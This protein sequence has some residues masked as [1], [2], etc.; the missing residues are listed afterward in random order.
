MQA[1]VIKALAINAI[2][3]KE[4][5]FRCLNLASHGIYNAPVLVVIKPCHARWKKQNCPSA[6]TKYQ[7]LHVAL[8]T[9][10]KPF[11]IFSVHLT[12]TAYTEKYQSSILP[13]D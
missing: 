11:V 3:T 4:L 5:N 2:Y 13:L 12:Y 8:Q 6:L 1:F 7:K 9:C 10:T